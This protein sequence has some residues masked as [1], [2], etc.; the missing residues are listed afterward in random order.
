MT[1][2]KSKKPKTE[3]RT[4]T[5]VYLE[6]R[7]IGG[8]SNWTKQ[9]AAK[10]YHGEVSRALNF[11][12]QSQYIVP[13]KK[14]VIEWLENN[15]KLLDK[16]PEKA[17]KMIST[18]R[19]STDSFTKETMMGVAKIANN[20][21]VLIKAHQD[22]L[23]NL[24][25]IAIDATDPDL[26]VEKKR[27]RKKVDDTP[28]KGLFETIQ[29]RML[30]QARTLAAE[31]DGD[32]DNVFMKKESEVDFYKFLV[33]NQVTKPVA[34]KMRTMFEDS[35]K[36]IVESKKKNGDEQL[37]EGYAFLKGRQLRNVIAWYE[38]LFADFDN[39]VKHKNLNRKVRKKKVVSADKLTAKLK[40]LKEFKQFR[41]VSIHPKDIV[42][43]QQL[44]VFN[45]KSRKLGRYIADVG[46]ALSVKGSTI[47]GYD[48]AAS[49]CKTIRK[50]DIQLP[51][52]MKSGKVALRT[53][54]DD[55]KA[56]ATKVKSRTGKDTILL[57]VV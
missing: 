57:R 53:F 49:V 7:Y 12:N 47:I 39:Y 8:E 38:K 42:G 52:F 33:D 30:E 14:D 45:V 48:E 36:E 37:Q 20:G 19:K 18:Y 54:L 25:K 29:S 28:V 9:P 26:V 2:L 34:S 15:S 1:A 17:R 40:Y 3:R 11:Y 41:V 51:A 6:E 32:L 5:S 43:A 23:I 21:L 31:F 13:R 24:V 56:T 27:G 16:K 10:D 22:Y 4:K 55:I 35:Y 50:P 44:W 46:G